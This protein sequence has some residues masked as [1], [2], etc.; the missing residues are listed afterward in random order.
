MKKITLLTILILS[1][2]VKSQ[3]NN[4]KY[5]DEIEYALT[6]YDPTMIFGY[7][8]EDIF[9]NNILIGRKFLSIG[10]PNKVSRILLN[11]ENGII[12]NASINGEVIELF[13]NKEDLERIKQTSS[14]DFKLNYNDGSLILLT[15]VGSEKIAYSLGF[16]EGKIKTI[17]K[18][19]KRGNYLDP[20]VSEIN[21]LEYIDDSF[22]RDYT[23]YK[24]GKKMEDKNIVQKFIYKYS[25][26]DENTYSKEYMNNGIKTDP[27]NGTK[28]VYTYDNKDRILSKLE[29]SQLGISLSEYLYSDDNSSEYVRE[30]LSGEF[31]SKKYKRIT[32]NEDLPKTSPNAQDYEWEKGYYEFDNNELVFIRKNGKVREKKNGIW[33]ER[34]DTID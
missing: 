12:K 15:Q 9:D 8:T 26:I 33:I 13:F 29:T 5:L 28:I 14:F 34:A 30:I 16:N 11:K 17:V 1:L 23:A 10:Y 18:A 2:S 3:T 6:A 22:I 7:K 32:I 21:K 25:K 19:I 31:K 24:Y 27:S 20:F 4:K